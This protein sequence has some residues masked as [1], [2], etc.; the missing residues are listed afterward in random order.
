VT[1]L[2]LLKL[3][4]IIFETSMTKEKTRTPKLQGIQSDV[5]NVIRD[6]IRFD[7]VSLSVVK[8]VL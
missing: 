8:I 1:L 2:L 4:N 7:F 6:F 5:L 3:D